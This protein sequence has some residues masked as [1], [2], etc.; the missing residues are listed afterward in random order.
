VLSIHK[1]LLQCKTR[2]RLE[3]AI[4]E[5][6]LAISDLQYLL[7][8]QKICPE[9]LSMPSK[10]PTKLRNCS[11]TRIQWPRYQHHARRSCRKK[12]DYYCG[13]YV[14]NI[15]IKCMNIMLI[16]TSLDVCEKK[17]KLKQRVQAFDSFGSLCGS[18]D[19]VEAPR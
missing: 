13:H 2:L 15:L 8:I 5:G 19:F 9:Q 18:L 3:I 16:F 1:R 11:W 6:N 14:N 7:L 17:Q 4:Q 12:C 10:I